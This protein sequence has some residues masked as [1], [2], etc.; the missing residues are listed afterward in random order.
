[1]TVRT[2]GSQPASASMTAREIRLI[3]AAEPV[4]LHGARRTL[5]WVICERLYD[6]AS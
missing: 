5:I 2:T 6:S 4:R 3:G 1:M